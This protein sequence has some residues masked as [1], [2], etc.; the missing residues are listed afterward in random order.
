MSLVV[1]AID[2]G[3]VN[4][5]IAVIRFGPDDGEEILVREII[6]VNDLDSRLLELQESL[7]PDI[8]VV[9]S[10][11]AGKTAAKSALNAG[12]EDI[13]IV[14]E[15]NTTIEAKYRYLSVNPAPWYIRI[16]PKSLRLPADHCD[17]W[18]AVILAERT[19]RG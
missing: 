2:P 3:S 11:T 18:A 13:R 16:I 4:C 12:L 15:Y 9:G 10:G 8:T 17:D 14:D 5:G 1:L 19:G 7:K 6:A